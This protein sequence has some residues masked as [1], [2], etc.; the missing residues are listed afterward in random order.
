MQIHTCKYLTRHS[1]VVLCQTHIN[2][3]LCSK[4]EQVL[5]VFTLRKETKFCTGSC[6]FYQSSCLVHSSCFVST[7]SNKMPTHWYEFN[8]ALSPYLHVHHDCPP[9]VCMPVT[10]TDCNGCVWKHILPDTEKR[11]LIRMPLQ[12]THSYAF[13]VLLCML[14]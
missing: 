2:S 13:I 11:Y 9:S 8:A 6:L 4:S 1:P 12:C 7:H 14:L 3:W 10:G 5:H